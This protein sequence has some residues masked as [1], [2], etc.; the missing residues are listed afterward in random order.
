MNQDVLYGPPPTTLSLLLDDP[1]E[2]DFAAARRLLAGLS[3]E[4]ALTAP[5]GLPYAIGEIVAH[6]NRN[7]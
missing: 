2:H 1:A 4:E 7:V 5:H 6:M 3:G